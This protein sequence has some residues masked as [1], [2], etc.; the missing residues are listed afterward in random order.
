[1]G[2]FEYI[3]Q[4][5]QDAI[6]RNNTGSVSNGETKGVCGG[7]VYDA[8]KNKADNT[9]AFTEASTRSNIASGETIPVILGKIK[10]YFSDLKD[11]AYIAKDGTNSTKFL[12]GDGTWQNIPSGASKYSDLSD[13]QLNQLAQGDIMYYNASAQKWRNIPYTEFSPIK[14]VKQ[15]TYTPFSTSSQK[16]AETDQTVPNGSYL[17]TGQVV[18]SGFSTSDVGE[19]VFHCSNPSLSQAYER[20]I[21]GYSD[22]TAPTVGDIP[23]PNYNNN[24]NV[25][26][27]M[28]INIVVTFLN[29]ISDKITLY[30]DDLYGLAHP[31][32]ENESGITHF[33]YLTTSIMILKIA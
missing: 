30:V 7:A 24:Y 11:L 13:V 16:I 9:T 23:D 17:V 18:V 15:I 26:F 27:V 4:L 29:D 28:P 20:Q 5:I 19:L 2:L 22:I 31:G 1:M 10:K 12:R 14:I 32:H 3:K 25:N 21:I 8:V 6:E 33:A